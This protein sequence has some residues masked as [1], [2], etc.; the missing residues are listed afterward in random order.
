MALTQHKSVLLSECLEYLAI[1]PGKTY[2]DCTLGAGG[3]SS[4]ILE[5]LAGSGQL[6][7]LDQ[8]LTAI[9]LVKASQ[10]ELN[11]KA[12]S[13]W[14]LAHQNFADLEEFYKQQKSK[15]PDFKIDGGI[16]LDLGVSSMQFDE[17]DRGFSF[18]KDAALDMRMDQSQ[19]FTAADLIN[20]YPEQ[21]I[22]DIL[23]TYGDERLS[24]QIARAVVSARPVNTTTELAELVKR[25]YVQKT[26]SR[27][28]FQIHPATRTFQA[29]RVYVNRELEVLETI[30]EAAYSLM[31]PN[32]RIVVISFQSQEDRLVKHALRDRAKW[33]LLTKKPVLPSEAEEAENPR[34][35]SA[36]LRAAFKHEHQQS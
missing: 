4:A 1:S 17:G 3:H 32:A 15:N 5:K 16:L 12:Y 22:A 18:T 19:D 11:P 8:D 35:R 36:K 6:Y 31:E 33:Q 9:E 29:L 27:K 2:I 7:S 10:P 26:K 13:N 25:I 28:T 34:A 23:Y 20:S 30:L 24:R 14:Y 21:Q